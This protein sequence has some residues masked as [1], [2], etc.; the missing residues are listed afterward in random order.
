MSAR[1]E[2][3]IGCKPVT[4]NRILSG[5]AASGSG[6]NTK[7]DSDADAL[8]CHGSPAAHIDE[9]QE[10]A[11]EGERNAR[12]CARHDRA[13]TVPGGRLISVGLRATGWMMLERSVTVCRCPVEDRLRR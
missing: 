8:A 11:A 4:P 1:Y 10:A 9:R 5:G 12:I 7:A 3:P 6:P 13:V 2:G